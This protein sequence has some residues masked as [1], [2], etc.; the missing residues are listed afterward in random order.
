MS[1]ESTI[2]IFDAHVSFEQPAEF[3]WAEG[4]I[5]DAIIDFLETDIFPGAGGG[6]VDPLTVPPDAPIGTDVAHLEAVGILERWRFVGHGAW[7]GS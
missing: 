7:G 6:D 1:F 2:G 5:P 4:D 3:E